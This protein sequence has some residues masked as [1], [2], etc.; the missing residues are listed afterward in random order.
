MSEDE[1]QIRGLVDTWLAATR[2]GD[3]ETVLSL[4]TEDVVFLVAGQPPFGKV[5]FSQKSAE[6][7]DRPLEFD[8][9]S[10]I[11]EIKIVGDHA[12]I[13]NWLA[14]KMKPAE[15]ERMSLSGYTLT[16]FRKENGRWLLARDA[17]FVAP[18]KQ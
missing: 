2:A 1:K 4:M 3:I 9:T 18:D 16:I 14:I 7:A 13:I 17:N 15:G 11:R 10:D 6:H 8:G 5:E 12:Y